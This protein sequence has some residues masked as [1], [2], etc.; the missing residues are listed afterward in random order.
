MVFNNPQQVMVFKI[1]SIKCI[2]Q[3]SDEESYQ[4]ILSLNL[5]L[6]TQFLVKV[7]LSG[8]FPLKRRVRHFAVSC[9][10]C[11]VTCSP[12]MLVLNEKYD[13]NNKIT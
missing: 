10:S 2:L 7:K 4:C 3:I 1:F 9:K 12:Q 13:T 5:K 6:K 11:F 8:T